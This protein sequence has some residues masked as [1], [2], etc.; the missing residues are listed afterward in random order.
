MRVAAFTDLTGPDGVELVDRD[1]PQPGE[2]EAVVDVRACSINRHDLWILQGDSAMVSEGALPF[3]SG[4]DVAGVVAETGP[5]AS[6]SEGDRVVL[7][8]NQ[9]CGTCRYCREGP[10]NLCQSFMLYHGGLAEQ[11]TVTAD[12]LIALPDDLS[13]RDAACLPTAYLTA[14]H[15]YRK[16]DVTA[17]D[18]VFV[19]GATGGVGVAAVQLGD[20]LGVETVGTTTSQRKADRL[21]D[22]GCS[23]VVV[24]GDPDDIVREVRG[25]GQVNAALNHLAGEFTE[26]AGKVLERGGRQVVCGRTAGSRVDTAAA[27][28]FLQ[29]QEIL[30]STMGTQ[31]ELE[32][33]VELVSD[34][35]FDPV[36]GGTYP[37]EETREAF[38]D[39]AER[40]AF[41]KLVVEP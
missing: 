28:F 40:D 10:E 2:G 19:P 7:C 13:F 37:L 29:H 33:L 32:R 16:A 6:V 18:T 20:V 4:L 17:G 36:V 35:A 22:I 9:T 21:D 24:S 15:M 3:V 34:G 39:M 5:G 30:G 8:P 25:V 27:P 14:W 12:R 26:V 41:G 1:D 31:P 38:R 23:H 11:A